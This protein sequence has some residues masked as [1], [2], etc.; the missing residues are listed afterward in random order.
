MPIERKLDYRRTIGVVRSEGRGTGISAGRR[1]L[2]GGW[3]WLGRGCRRGCR[4]AAIGSLSGMFL[5]IMRDWRL[6]FEAI[7][8]LESIF[9]QKIDIL[10][11]CF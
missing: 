3:R 6:E 1:F 9:R 4:L 11:K 10:K 8:I 2:C 7:I 5:I